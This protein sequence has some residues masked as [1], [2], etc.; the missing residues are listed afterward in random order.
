MSLSIKLPSLVNSRV[1][2][3]PTGLSRFAA[4]TIRGPLL[5]VALPA[6]RPLLTLPLERMKTEKMNRSHGGVQ[7]KPHEKED[8]MPAGS[9]LRN[10]G[11]MVVPSLYE[12]LVI[13]NGLLIHLY[14]AR[15]VAL[16]EGGSDIARACRR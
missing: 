4:Q 1:E 10:T 12:K 14:G 15:A 9:C 16:G 8:L 13:V 5:D 7:K 6:D 3:G 2:L 11:T